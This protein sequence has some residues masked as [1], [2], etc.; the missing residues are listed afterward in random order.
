MPNCWKFKNYEIFLEN[1]RIN[2]LV[3]SL[4]YMEPGGILG[5]KNNLSN[6]DDAWAGLMVIFSQ[7]W[8]GSSL[9]LL[10][11]LGSE[12]KEGRNLDPT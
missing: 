2:G 3:E 11:D 8:Y 7:V 4:S 6:K 10:I 9:N 12:E 5:K 1:G